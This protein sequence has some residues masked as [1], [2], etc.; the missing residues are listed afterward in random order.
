MFNSNCITLSDCSLV[1]YQS[2]DN[3]EGFFFFFFLKISLFDSLF[4]S[5]KIIVCHPSCETCDGGNKTNC[6]SCSNSYLFN[7][8][9]IESCP[10]SYY[11]NPEL[12]L[13]ESN[14]YSFMIFFVF[15]L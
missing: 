3:C 1:G 12:N 13:C 15:F 14:F 9:C 5:L 8:E 11:P 4:T 10:E 7:G 2:G 6:L